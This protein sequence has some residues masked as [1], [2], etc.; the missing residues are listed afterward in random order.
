VF[1]G[2]DAFLADPALNPAT[3]RTIARDNA[4]ALFPTIA[5]RLSAGPH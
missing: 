3:R 4:L 1:A 2:R 5:A